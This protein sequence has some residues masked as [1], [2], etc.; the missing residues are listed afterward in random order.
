MAIKRS[1]DIDPKLAEK[2]NAEDKKDGDKWEKGDYGKNPKFMADASPPMTANIQK[3]VESLRRGRPRSEVESKGVFMNL[4]VELLA[5]IKLQ[6]KQLNIGYQ[7]YIKIAL[8]QYLK[9]AEA[10]EASSPTTEK[11]VRAKKAKRKR[12]A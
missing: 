12:R 10:V 3:A 8:T 6:A 5:A 7:S 9:T 11:R 4:P 2:W 1:K